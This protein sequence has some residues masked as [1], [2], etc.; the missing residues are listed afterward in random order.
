MTLRDDKVYELLL[1][2]QV[3]GGDWISYGLYSTASRA[4]I[5][6]KD[7]V[8]KYGYVVGTEYK[9]TPRVVR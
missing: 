5:A 9:V 4:E 7:L 6:Y 1:Y 3:D 2:S 8:A